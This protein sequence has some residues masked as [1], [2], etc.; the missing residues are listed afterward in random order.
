VGCPD[1]AADPVCSAGQSHTPT[2]DALNLRCWAQKQRFGV[3]LLYP[4]K[5]YVDALTSPFITPRPG[6]AQVPN[7]L[8][9]GGRDPSLIVLGG[10]VGVPWQDL[11]TPETLEEPRR[12][13][14]L[15]AS[16]L[17]QEG[18]WDILLGEP[19]A[20]VAPRDT[21]MVESVD[22]RTGS[23]L[24]QA[25]PLVPGATIGA[26]T[27]TS[28]TNPINGHELEPTTTRD[29]LQYACIFPLREPLPCDGLEPSSC[30]CSAQY[31]AYNSPLCTGAS[32]DADGVQTHGKAT[33][34][35]R[36]L[37]V[38]KGVGEAA[39]VGSICPK[40]TLPEGGSPAADPEY[41]YQ[42][43]VRSLLARL[44]AS[45]SP[46]CLPR[47]LAPSPS[48]PKQVAC[49]IVEVTP[50]P[51]GSC[52]CAAS[53][54]AVPAADVATAVREVMTE[55]GLCGQTGAASCGDYCLCGIEQLSGAE[56]ASCQGGEP[57]VTPGFCYIDPARGFGSEEAVASCPETQ[58]RL[59]RF[60]GDNV[61]AN[62]AM[63]FVAC[64]L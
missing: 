45:L 19:S 41:G 36:Q 49:G 35:L 46:R 16:E 60:T 30:P 63:T 22:P 39:V 17:E 13:D 28:L 31:S 3:D 20:G 55:S 64:D 4:T 38:L 53:G 58:K 15:S 62:G 2:S 26:S 61:P 57:G 51:G 21:L 9:A 52:D 43:F 47:T 29:Q 40:N 6:G 32:A 14:Y 24:P 10:I 5:R 1:N 56:L 25:H 59:L 27:A 48:N 54:R 34:S 23:G 7:P 8:L 18:R 50:A 44:G 37:E 11:A 12:L 42:P 33:P